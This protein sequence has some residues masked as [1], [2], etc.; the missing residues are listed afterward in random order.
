VPEGHTIHRLAQDHAGWFAGSKVRVSSPQGRFTTAADV[1]D[2]AHLVATDAWGKHL[3]HHF[4]GGRSVH[5]HLGLFGKV[6]HHS[7]DPSDADRK[8]PPAPRDTVR[9]RVQGR[10]HAID[11]VGATACELVDEGQIEA[12]VARLGPDPIRDD[13]DPERAWAALQ[14]RSVGIGRALMDQSVLAGVGNVY[15]AEVLY[16]HGLHPDVPSRDVPRDVWDAV[17][18]TLVVWLRRG[19]KERRII[20]VDPKELGMPRSRI[21]RADATYVYHQDH[22]RRCG[23]AIRR[24]DLA[25]R[26]AYACET[27]QPPPGRATRPARRPSTAKAS[28]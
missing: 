15:R 2:R 14:R 24:Y 7:L 19:V 16:V 23:T 18:S 4:D 9:Y 6:F 28:R 20:T 27:C 25:G 21:R 17:W 12:I 1:L 13:A 8:M 3:F 26:W 10:D 22:C 5:I 11:L